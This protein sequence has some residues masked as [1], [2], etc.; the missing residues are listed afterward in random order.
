VAFIGQGI[1]DVLAAAHANGI[2][3]RD[4]KPENIF[5]TTDNRVV[6]LDFGIARVMEGFGEVRNEDR[7]R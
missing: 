6:V 1:L 3:H 5:L 7:Q 4:I 2:I